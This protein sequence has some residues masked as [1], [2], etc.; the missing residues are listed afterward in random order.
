M[1]KLNI[2]EQKVKQSVVLLFKLSFT[3]VIY[4]GNASYA[5][6]LSI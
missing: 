3:Y 5:R 1:L 4:N 6:V 2:N